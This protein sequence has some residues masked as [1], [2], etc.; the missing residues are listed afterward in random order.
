M[1]DL[2]ERLRGAVVINVADAHMEDLAEEAATEIEQLQARLRASD[3]LLAESSTQLRAAADHIG[4]L[5]ARLD[6]VR[7][8]LKEAMEWN[9]MD[10]GIPTGIINKCEGALNDN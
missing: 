1:S 2:V 7:E 6:K 3:G 5:Q 8:A 10:D 9:W 4:Q